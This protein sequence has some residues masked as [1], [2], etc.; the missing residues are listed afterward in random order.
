MATQTQT[1]KSGTGEVV[2]L[3]LPDRPAAPLSNV[4]TK[5]EVVTCRA[6]LQDGGAAAYIWTASGMSDVSKRKRLS[7][8]RDVK[9]FV[10]SSLSC[11]S[12]ADI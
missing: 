10:T 12:G 7:S 1:E 6:R 9:S 8:K 5:S 3:T 2:L 11:G 4:P